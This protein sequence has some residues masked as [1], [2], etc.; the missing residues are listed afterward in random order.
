[1]TVQTQQILFL[2]S[3][4]R[5]RCASHTS[6]VEQAASTPDPTE[7]QTLGLRERNR[8]D[9]HR[10]YLQAALRIVFAEG[11]DALTMQRLADEVGAAVG[12]VYTYFPSKGALV[13]EVQREA[14]ERLASSVTRLGAELDHE[15]ASDDPA[16]LLA[17]IVAFGRFWLT[18][19]DVYP[20]E[21]RL[22]LILLSPATPTIP[23]E[24]GVRVVPSAL[25][26]LGLAQTRIERATDAGVLD[27]SASP[28]S[29]TVAFAAAL[30]G[31]VQLETVEFWD[32]DLLRPLAIGRQVIDT[33]LH[34]WG[35]NRDD[36]RAAHD[37]V[38]QL[39]VQHR[40][41]EA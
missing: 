19:S 18:A 28:Q 1:M 23:P 32:P 7:P 24:E 3:V 16:H 29:R 4:D 41:P 13:A 17:P 26:L 20:E 31:C 30:T 35:A 9:R 27:D 6:R 22:L 40:D 2:F 34:G 10:S 33:L 38:D 37:I 15:P 12:G 5:R 14:I 25:R 11:L 21:M 8:L 39:R 36:L